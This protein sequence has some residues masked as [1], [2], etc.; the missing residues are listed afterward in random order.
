[1]LSTHGLIRLLRGCILVDLRCCLS[2]KKLDVL[3]GPEPSH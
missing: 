1:M 2:P 3:L